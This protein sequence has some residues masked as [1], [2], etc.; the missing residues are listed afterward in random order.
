MVTFVTF[1]F[2][3]PNTRINWG[4]L[5]RILLASIASITM[6][7]C[8]AT[9]KTNVSVGAAVKECTAATCSGA[10]PSVEAAG[11]PSLVIAEDKVRVISDGHGGY[12][13]DVA[14]QKSSA[15]ALVNL[16]V[17]SDA[18]CQTAVAT[19][20]T[21]SGE[22]FQ[23]AL[24]KIPMVAYLCLY[25]VDAEGKA[26]PAANN[27]VKFLVTGAVNSS[28]PSP[29]ASPPAPPSPD[30]PAPSLVAPSPTP[31]PGNFNLA[32]VSGDGQ[33]TL[34]WDTAIYA[35]SYTL[36]RGTT[37]GSYPTTVSVNAT[38]PLID[39]GL[40]NG[41]VYYYMVTATGAG[42][43]TDGNAEAAATPI[44]A[45]TAPSGFAAAP[46]DM[47]VA[48][49][50]NSVADASSYNV[51]KATTA[52]G[53]FSA[54]ATGIGSPFYSDT[55]LTNG[56]QYYYKV[57]AVNLGGP[58][59]TTAPISATPRQLPGAF[60]ITSANSSD[61]QVTIS[62]GN[63]ASA[64]SYNVMRGVSSGNYTTT[65][66]GVSPYVD[67]GLTNGTLYYYR[68]TAVNA[69]GSTPATLEV[70]AKPTA[71]AGANKLA[72]TAGPASGIAGACLAAYT[73]TVQD[74]SGSPTPT[75]V[76]LT[77][78]LAK[79]GSGSATFYSDADC[80]A[81]I[82]ALTITA[83]QTTRPFYFRDNAVEATTIQ[84]S[85]HATNLASGTLGVTFASAT[86]MAL[87]QSFGCA[88]A[89]GGVKCWGANDMGQLGNNTTAN[90]SVAVTA[91]PTNSGVTAVAAWGGSEYKVIHVNW[92]SEVPPLVCAVVSGGVQ[93]WGNLQGA[94][95]ASPLA[96][97]PG[98]SG[99]SDVSVASYG[100][101]QDACAIVKGGVKCWGYNGSG[102]LGDGT[103]TTQ[104]APV[105]VVGLGA[106]SGAT[107]IMINTVWSCALVSGGLSCWGDNS[108]G[109]LGDGTLTGRHS[110]VAPIA[111]ASGVTD[112]Y[113][114]DSTAC[115]IVA[116][117]VKCWGNDASGQVGDGGSANRLTPYAVALLGA[118][119]VATAV[120]TGDQ[121][122][123]A[124]VGG[125][126]QC[127][128]AN[129]SGQ[130]GNNTSTMS[131][132]P[133]Q[134]VG[135]GAG[136]GATSVRT[137]DYFTCATVA[138]GVQCWGN[139]QLGAY[140]RLTPQVATAGGNGYLLAQPATY[141]YY[142]YDFN[143]DT[144]AGH[145]EAHACAYA[146]GAAQCWG[147]NS[148]LEL[149][150]GDNSGTYK[151]SPQPVIGFP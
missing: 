55:G 59:P 98:D 96:I 116:G 68:V 43:S 5:S 104:T 105:D 9:V 8:S 63:S 142:T 52:G 75:L 53:S 50:W 132:T 73:V 146:A 147:G 106:G 145:T 62:W 64:T 78:D 129:G 121:A 92:I 10:N 13:L 69:A 118:S 88:I 15:T 141:T 81:P 28:S 29:A 58:G 4:T 60:S 83:N 120:A 27:G 87:A 139:D 47:T 46:G 148:A 115:A 94:A 84:V 143:T 138:G 32:A 135:L 34:S 102:Q 122:T 6:S 49:S 37:S 26:T 97:I 65:V 70:S 30:T 36:R 103:T 67:S 16:V 150:D 133:V 111:A 107:K 108:S 95:Q 57:Q 1:K 114:Q 18:K 125:G 17:A 151:S 54:A 48:L 80:S 11:H 109:Q 117:G 14:W 110:P 12:Q 76:T 3:V 91:I 140:A 74:S 24:P 79:A 7:G 33:L 144:Y 101:V 41:Q 66:S 128:G 136:S 100:V 31:A 39:S 25:L 127:W 61:G 99:V 90:S 51:L 71:V 89:G 23:A 119:P 19:F 82:T 112:F 72:I 56:V 124:I 86:G 126:V 22:T 35:T 123:C 42:G 45:P 44:A 93:C 137:K 21:L 134:V 130:L 38:S 40:T 85:D 149:G 2:T 20:A 131:G 77:V 113:I